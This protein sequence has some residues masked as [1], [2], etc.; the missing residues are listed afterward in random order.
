LRCFAYYEVLE[1]LEESVIYVNGVPVVAA[2]NPTI[3]Y[4]NG[5]LMALM[6]DVVLVMISICML[7]L[8]RMY[9]KERDYLLKP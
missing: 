7:Y 1:G 8:H 9:F 3:L 5:V 6:F 4:E 2:S